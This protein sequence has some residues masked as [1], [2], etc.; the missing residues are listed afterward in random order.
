MHKVFYEPLEPEPKRSKLDDLVDEK[1][2]KEKEVACTDNKLNES[3]YENEA[4]GNTVEDKFDQV[5]TELE[6]MFAGSDSD[7]YVTLL[8]Q[9]FTAWWQ[10]QKSVPSK[11]YDFWAFFLFS[12]SQ[13]SSISFQGGL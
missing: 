1:R 13:T 8:V 5:E 7:R 4:I 6:A 9:N 2:A 11:Y 3:E 12:F 10:L